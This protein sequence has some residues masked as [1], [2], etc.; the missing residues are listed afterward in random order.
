MI[1]FN[2]I[3]RGDRKFIV[4]DDTVLETI[5]VSHTISVMD[6]VMISVEM[7]KQYVLWHMNSVV[8]IVSNELCKGCFGRTL[9]SSRAGSMSAECSVL[10]FESKLR[11]S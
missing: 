4:S 2:F 7:V 5:V 8:F 3:V 1:F 6:L 9:I 11:C 10:N